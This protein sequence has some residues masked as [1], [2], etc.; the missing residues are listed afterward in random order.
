M[1]MR[2]ARRDTTT[3]CTCT[4]LAYTCFTCCYTSSKSQLVGLYSLVGHH[5][6]RHWVCC[7]GK[8]RD[9]VQVTACTRFQLLQIGRNVSMCCLYTNYD[10]PPLYASYTANK[11]PPLH[12]QP[13]SHH[14]Y[15]RTT[16]KPLPLHAQ[17]I[18]HYPYMHNR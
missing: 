9:V 17:L 4:T 16:D 7:E 2:C 12:A 18:S 1:E 3:P 10:Q 5:E 6:S 11:P 13:I 8:V 14:P 15:T